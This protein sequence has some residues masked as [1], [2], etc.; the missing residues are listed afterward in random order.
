MLYVITFASFNCLHVL[1]QRCL[2]KAVATRT[3]AVSL[4]LES[5]STAVI[6]RMRISL[7]FRLRELYF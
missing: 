7:D 3:W 1:V 5:K 2:L 6:L 4:D